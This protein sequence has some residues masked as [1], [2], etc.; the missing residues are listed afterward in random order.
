MA[1]FV[2]DVMLVSTDFQ[3]SLSN[4]IVAEHPD[5][6]SGMRFR[7]MDDPIC[8]NLRI[9]LK[10]TGMPVKCLQP[11]VVLFLESIPGAIFQ[12][13]NV[14]SHVAK[15]GRNFCSVQCMQLLPSSA[16]SDM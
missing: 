7:I 11:E 3:S 14:H 4:D 12:Q 8:H 5:L 10:A 6:Q 2:L 13:D 15:S 9:I 16:I 1:A